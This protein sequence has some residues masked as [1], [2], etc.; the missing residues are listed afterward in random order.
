MIIS[1]LT[2]PRP[3]GA[4]YLSQTLPLWQSQCDPTIFRDQHNRGSRALMRE[5]LRWFVGQRW[6][7]RLLYLEDDVLPCR[8]VASFAAVIEFNEPLLSLFDPR[9]ADPQPRII[10]MNAAAFQHTQAL[11]I[12]RATAERLVELPYLDLKSGCSKMLRDHLT[13]LGYRTYAACYPNPVKHIGELSAATGSFTL[14]AGNPTW[15]GEEADAYSFKH[16]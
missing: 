8:N 9:I 10:R 5:I 4:D 15:P 11:I 6:E 2:A 14:V 13:A 1:I 3:E 12:P 16:Q 7:D